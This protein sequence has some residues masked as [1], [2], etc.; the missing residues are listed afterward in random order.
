MGL[1]R[2]LIGGRHT[3]DGSG[4]ELR[5]PRRYELAATIGFAGLRRR[6]FDGL[7]ALS[8]AGPGDRVLD[9]GCGTGYL[10]RRVARAV[11]ADGSVVGI[12]PSGPMV[13]HARRTSPPHCR[14]HIAGAQAIPE[15]DASFDVVVSS[16]AVHHIPTD[17]RTDAFREMHRVLRPDG[18]LLIADL[19]PT[20][21]LSVHQIPGD[22]V[23]R[24]TDLVTGAG[25]R[26]TD[27]GTRRPR[28][29]Y[30]LAER[31]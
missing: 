31:V 21:G 23:E 18:R 22:V 4:G 29:Y 1:T 16:F 6:V 13:A 5:H 10:T 7:V 20:T 24:V 12:D 27:T 30:L 9:V 26:I 11:G 8:G 2:R 14:F 3:H 19:R 25:F 17:L 15:P 28:L